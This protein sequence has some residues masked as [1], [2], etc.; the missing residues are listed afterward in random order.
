[1]GMR[2][3]ESPDEDGVLSLGI[4]VASAA[5]AV[6]VALAPI[7]VEGNGD[8]ARGQCPVQRRPIVADPRIQ[9][10]MLQRAALGGAFR[11]WLVGDD[12]LDLQILALISTPEM[13][14]VCRD[15]GI[16]RRQDEVRR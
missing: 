10:R 8:V 4:G 11:I 7:A 6:S 5:Q 15:W 14:R 12:L 2:Y 13:A 1:M 9:A 3:G 16:G